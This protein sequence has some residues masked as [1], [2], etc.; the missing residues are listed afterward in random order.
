MVE[1]WIAIFLQQNLF[2]CC[3]KNTQQQFITLLISLKGSILG[4]TFLTIR[5]GLWNNELLQRYSGI[6]K[7]LTKGWGSY[8]WHTWMKRLAPGTGGT[9]YPGTSSVIQYCAMYFGLSLHALKDSDIIS[10]WSVLMGLICMVN[11]DECCWLQWP[12]MPITRFCLLPLLLWTN[13]QGLV[14]GGF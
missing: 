5:Y 2:H 6:G 10:Q 14:R 11:I 13:S 9:P 4:I 3:K 8:Y 12:S 7:S 1:W